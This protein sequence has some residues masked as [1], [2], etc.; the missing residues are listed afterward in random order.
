MQNQT[1][2]DADFVR[3]NLR[4]SLQIDVPID[5]AHCDEIWQETAEKLLV[6]SYMQPLETP[7]LPLPNLPEY[8]GNLIDCPPLENA[9]GWT[10]WKAETNEKISNFDAVQVRLPSDFVAKKPN[11]WQVEQLLTG[12]IED[13][14]LARSQQIFYLSSVCSEKIRLCLETEC[15]VTEVFKILSYIALRQGSI[16]PICWKWSEQTAPTRNIL[17]S[18]AKLVKTS[19]GVPPIMTFVEI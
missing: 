5:I 17:V 2:P 14:N 9:D 11:L 18:V 15:T 10:K 16:P 7:D 6:N 1:S 12:K 19:V 8:F 13:D 4:A 3:K